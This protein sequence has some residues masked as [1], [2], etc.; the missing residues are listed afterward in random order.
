M[1]VAIA[2]SGEVLEV[3]R[4]PKLVMVDD[5]MA[6]HKWIG[7]VRIYLKIDLS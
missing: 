7:S 6:E 3:G 5:C 2:A 1:D 4:P